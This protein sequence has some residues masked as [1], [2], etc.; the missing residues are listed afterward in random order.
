MSTKIIYKSVNIFTKIYKYASPYKAKNREKRRGSI[1]MG[2]QEFLDRSMYR[3]IKGMNCEQ[4]EAVIHEFYDMVAK[5]A[6]SVSV[7]MQA[8]KQDI[9]QIKG[10]GASRLNEIMAVIEKHLTPSE[11]KE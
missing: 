9:G 6:E 7:D 3:R 4:M 1:K 11:E 8:I 5:S 10:V 2:K